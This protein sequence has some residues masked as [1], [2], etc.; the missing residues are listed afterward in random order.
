MKELKPPRPYGEADIQF[1]LAPPP[2]ARNWALAWL[3]DNVPAGRRLVFVAPGSIQPHKRWPLA[4]FAELI[5]ALQQQHQELHF[6][7]IG[8]GSDHGLGEQLRGLA[9]ERCSNLAGVTSLAQSAA[10]LQHDSLVVGNDGGA[11]HLGDAMGAK[12]VSIVPGIEY[13]I[14]IE[15]WNNRQR[16]VRHPVPCAPC[17]SFVNCP[18]GHNRCM[19]DLPVQAVLDQCNKAL[20]SVLVLRHA[21][22]QPEGT[23]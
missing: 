16:A 8:T 18:Q 3:N 17:Y 15:P 11:M 10:L 4:L 9:P 14:S 12:V 19:T 6:I 20:A 13:P 7:V 22:A 5:T 2:E 23:T 1:L 21:V